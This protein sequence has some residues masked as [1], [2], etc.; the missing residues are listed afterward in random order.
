MNAVGPAFAI[1][2]ALLSESAL[3]LFSPEFSRLF[4]PFL[5]I[6][7]YYA[8]LKG[9]THGMLVGVT[10]GWVQDV[11]FGSRVLGLIGFSRTVVA[12]L[13]GLIA[14]RFL[15]TGALMRGL[16]IFLA[17]ILDAWLYESLAG[18]FNL[19]VHVLSLSDLLL[20]SAVTAVLGTLAF[21]GIDVASKRWNRP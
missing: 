17:S 12:F 3:S 11:H 2:L 15:I 16:V 8:L 4:D 18:L 14:S 20:R 7:V 6:A 10:A 9:E 21:S 19:P 5:L 13:V 1:L